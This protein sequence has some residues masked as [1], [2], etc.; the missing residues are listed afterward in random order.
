M[1]PLPTS[2]TCRGSTLP[3]LGLTRTGTAN[4]LAD[5]DGNATGTFTDKDVIHN[6]PPWRRPARSWR[7]S[8]ARR[9]A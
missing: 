2:Y 9:T 1:G 7:P 3:S 8:R 4:T 5:A 6:A